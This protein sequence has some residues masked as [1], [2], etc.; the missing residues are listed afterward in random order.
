MSLFVPEEVEE[1]G[2]KTVT[3]ADDVEDDSDSSVDESKLSVVDSANEDPVVNEIPIHLSPTD[4][5]LMLLQYTTRGSGKDGKLP[6]SIQWKKK[7][8]VVEL[9]LP[10]DQGK[11][12]NREKAENWTGSETGQLLRGVVGQSEDSGYYIGHVDDAGELRLTPLRG[13]TAQLRPSFKYIDEAK[14]RKQNEESVA[15]GLPVAVDITDKRSLHVV[16]MTAKSPNQA[17]PRLGAALMSK[18]QEDEEQAD[19]YDLKRAGQYDYEEIKK[20]LELDHG[21]LEAS[22]TASDYVE[23]LMSSSAE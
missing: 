7:S 1:K 21:V 22:G 3:W 14:L 23:A 10:F 19:E 11:Y 2:S 15:N 17:V 4:L 6:D 20:K 9:E 12:L 18:K 16:Q 5:K 13:G 8:G